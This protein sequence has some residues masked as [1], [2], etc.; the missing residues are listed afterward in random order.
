MKQLLYIC[1]V[2]LAFTACRSS[3]NIEKSKLPSTTTTT[4]VSRVKAAQAAAALAYTQKVVSHKVNSQCI[5]ANAKVRITGMGQ[6]LECQ[7]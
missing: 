6:R 3:K 5:S 7:W 4:E 1:L 2:V